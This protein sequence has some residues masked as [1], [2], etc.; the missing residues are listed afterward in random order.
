MARKALLL[1]AA[2]VALALVVAGWGWLLTHSLQ[3]SIEPTDDDV[4]RWFAGERTSWLDPVSD[5]GTLLG[6]TPVGLGVGAVVALVAG[7]AFRSVAAAALVLLADV[8]DGGIYWLGTTLDPRD[9]PP[10]AAHGLRT[11]PGPQLPVGP[12]RHRHRGVRRGG[13]PR[14]RCGSAAGHGRRR[15]AACSS[16]CWPAC[17][18][19]S[20]SAGSTRAR[21]T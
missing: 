1:V 11:G 16:C 21:T 10:V 14:S 4:S 3:G 9:R 18:C 6:E 7:F 8:G 19:T 17:R 12:R 20:R 2:Y 13:A 5:I 15:W